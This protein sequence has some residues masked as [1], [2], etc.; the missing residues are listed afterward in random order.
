MDHACPEPEAQARTHREGPGR[1]RPRPDALSRL[2][3]SRQDARRHAPR[4]H[5][6]QD[7]VSQRLQ[8]P[9][10][11]L[12]RHRDD[13]VAH[14]RRRDHEPEDARRRCVRPVRADHASHQHGRGLPLQERRGHG[15]DAH[16]RDEAA[17]RDLPGRLRPLVVSLAHVLRPARQAERRAAAA[18]AVADEDGQE[19]RAASAVRRPLRPGRDRSGSEDPRRHEGRRG[20]GHRQAS[21]REPPPRRGDRPLV[22]H[23]AGLEEFFKVIR[24]NGPCNAH[25]LALRRFSYEQGRWVRSAIAEG[26]TALPPAA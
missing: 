13:P 25:R 19:R 22:V 4:P 3:G 21:R 14:R 20:S 9:G 5:H 23:R 2:A 10:A 26:S 18:D 7:E 17:A 15:P 8:L 24:G 1:G 12:G 16:E 6:R 11:D